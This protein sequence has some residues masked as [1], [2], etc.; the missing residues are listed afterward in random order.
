MSTDQSIA[1]SYCFGG[2][3]KKVKFCCRDL[4]PELAS[5]QR[6]FAGEQFAAAMQLLDR[7]IAEGK[8]KGPA[9]SRGAG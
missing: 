9:C 8:D 1:Y 7:L 3:G 5:V 6:M 2:T 4:L